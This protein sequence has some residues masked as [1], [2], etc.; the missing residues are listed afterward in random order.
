MTGRP[1]DLPTPSEV[2]VKR[3]RLQAVGLTEAQARQAIR[4]N[5]TRLENAKALRSVIANLPKA[6]R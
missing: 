4:P 5:R 1:D 2:D 6:P 3:Q